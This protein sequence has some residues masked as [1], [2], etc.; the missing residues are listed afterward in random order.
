MALPFIIHH[1]FPG[2]LSMA[3]DYYIV[4]GVS[5]GADLERIKRAY[6]KVAKK[7]HPDTSRS[8]E[9][10]DRFCEAQEAFET[11]ADT[12][13]RRRYDRELEEISSDRI[14]R[15]PEIVRTHR[16]S[17]HE[18]V[19]SLFSDADDFFSGFLGGLFDSR[20]GRS[21]GK[22]LYVEALL[23]PAEA[24]EGGLYPVTVPVFAQCPRCDGR[25]KWEDFFCPACRG[26]GRVRT[27]R[28]FSLSIPPHVKD[29]T[30]I[31]LSLEDIGL[32]NTLLHIVVT[33]DPDLS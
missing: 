23:S 26:Y 25:G 4:L 8:E 18:R 33:I 14:K 17:Y 32:R 20:R 2:F 5:R 31:T 10:T 16:K 13:K 24:L 22:D 3:K 15:V 6:R 21:R 1:F 30:H 29:G 27:E 28:E 11:L 9:T 19:E 12:E 7:Y